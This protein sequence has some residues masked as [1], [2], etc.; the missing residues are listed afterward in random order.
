VTAEER[1]KGGMYSTETIAGSINAKRKGDA[2]E[3]A[4]ECIACLTDGEDP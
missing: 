4:E 3:K 1:A 2:L